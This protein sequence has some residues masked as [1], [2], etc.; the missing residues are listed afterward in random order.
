MKGMTSAA[1]RMLFLMLILSQILPRAEGQPKPKPTPEGIFSEAASVLILVNDA[2]GPAQGTGK[3][4]ASVWLG[5][6]Y[7]A[8]RGIPPGNIVHL[9]VPNS[10][11]PLAWDSWFVDWARVEQNILAPVRQFLRSRDL[12]NRIHYIVPVFG[13]PSHFT[14][15]P[16]F[17]GEGWSVDSYLAALNAGTNRL[18]VRNPYRSGTTEAQVH[19]RDWQ[20]PAGWKMYLVS[21]LDGPTVQI[22]AALVDKA[23]RAESN[24]KR[25]DGIGYFDYRHQACCDG[26]YQADLSMVNAY[27]L[28]MTNGFRSVLNDQAETKSLIKQAPDTLW[29]WGWYSGPSVNTGYQFVEGAV[30]AQLTSY[31]ANSIRTERPGTWVQLWLQAGITATWGATC[32]PTVGGYALGDNLL[33]HFWNGYNFAESAY[34]A[35]PFLNH[36]MVF[37]GDPLYAPAIFRS[38]SPRAGG[39]R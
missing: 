8:K 4:G 12:T 18:L 38:G 24:L 14:G 7:A 6:Y 37:V 11:N 36:T 32:E 34:L 3:K 5:Q 33:Y 28:S 29:A 9:N 10:E 30:G 31:S 23:I 25:P 27:K 35:S 17:K 16:E 1:R 19:F 21:R 2:V 22:A 39:A 13:V 26:M 20:N 15:P